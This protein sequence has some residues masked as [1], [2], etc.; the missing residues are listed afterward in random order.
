[1]ARTQ[2]LAGRPLPIIRSAD[3]SS[4]VDW[5]AAL[6]VPAWAR[7]RSDRKPR[8]P[9]SGGSDAVESSDPGVTSRPPIYNRISQSTP[10]D[11]TM[12]LTAC[13]II[14]GSRLPVDS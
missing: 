11:A 13:A 2:G 12:L 3:G 14:P 7:P 6:A 8:H 4:V 9:I 10:A 1:M 5:Q